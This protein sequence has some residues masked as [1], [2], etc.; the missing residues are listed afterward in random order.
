MLTPLDLIDMDYCPN[1]LTP[2]TRPRV[3][4]SSEGICNACDYADK[5]SANLIDYESRSDEFLVY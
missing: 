5:R 4:L 3:I 2:S 1:C